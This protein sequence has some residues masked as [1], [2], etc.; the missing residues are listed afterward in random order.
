MKAISLT[1]PYATL[2]AIGAK[3]IETRSWSTSFRGPLAIHAAKGLGPVGGEEGLLDL[4]VTEPFKSALGDLIR[5]GELA[6]GSRWAKPHWITAE[7]LPRGAIVA[8]CEL[9]ECV[10]S[11]KIMQA[12]G[13]YGPEDDS[14]GHIV[15]TLSDQ[16]IAFGNYAPG[17]YAWLLADI[18]ALPEPI[19]ARGALS[20]WEYEG[21]L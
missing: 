1:Q 16:E 12:F 13:A 5:V 2:V 15:W 10:P 11:E 4:I 21:K 3:K 7:R 18:R 8:V 6:K 20:L 9:V 17:R 14:G 19:P